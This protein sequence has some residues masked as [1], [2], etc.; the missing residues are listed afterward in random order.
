[1]FSGTA[2]AFNQLRVVQSDPGGDAQ[3][4]PPI[5]LPGPGDCGGVGLDHDVD[6]GQVGQRSASFP[7]V[8]VW[9]M[10]LQSSFMLTTVQPSCSAFASDASAAAV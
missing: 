7:V 8:T 5:E 1:M 6:R 9:Y 2:S 10:L 3:R 4:H